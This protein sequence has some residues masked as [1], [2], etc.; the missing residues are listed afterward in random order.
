MMR[1]DPFVRRIRR[2][3]AAARDEPFAAWAELFREDRQ[4]FDRALEAAM[5]GQDPSKQ[6]AALKVL[7]RNGELR[8]KAA[9]WLWTLLLTE[10][11]PLE[12]LE[13]LEAHAHAHQ[14]NP[15]FWRDQALALA[16]T[17]LAWEAKRAADRGLGRDPGERMQELHRRILELRTL[18][19]RAHEFNEWEPFRRL[20]EVELGF[21]LHERAERTL[22]I[23]GRSLI[24]AKAQIGPLSEMAAEILSL[25]TPDRA[26]DFLSGIRTLFRPSDRR[27]IERF[28]AA[29]QVEPDEACAG[30]GREALCVMA[31]A[32]MALGRREDAILRLA[33]LAELPADAGAR[34]VLA[35]EV[36][37]DVLGRYGFELG[38]ARAGRKIFDVFPFYNELRMLD[39]RLHEMADW[40]DQFVIVES[41]QTF[42]GRPKPLVFALHR[43]RYA[44]FADKILHVVVDDYPP[45][46]DSAWAREFHQRNMGLN[47][48]S[49]RCAADDLVLITDVDEV[50][51]REA[52]A[53]FDGEFASLRMEQSRYFLNYRRI[54]AAGEQ[55]PGLTS[56][57]KARYLTTMGL[58][59][60]R[61]A[62]PHVP[63]RAK[64]FDAGWHFSSAADAGAIGEK[65]KDISH[66][67][68]AGH[69]VDHFG[70]L[71]EAIRS[72]GEPEP[73]WRRVDVDESFPAYVRRNRAELGDLIL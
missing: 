4:G 62:L 41:A 53:G 46:I 39:L 64:I 63:G 61:A 30:A 71:F 19:A 29:P 57:W 58:S 20:A 32:S 68:F 59:Y 16:C 37:R 45:Y 7:H 13:I 54:I 14:L 42:T 66:Q 50:V 36:T 6:M 69:G 3:I 49:G 48:L 51:A 44:Q 31:L 38:A 24:L 27:L 5:A 60:A 70:P 67:E 26:A 47:A 25:T 2:D 1:V 40:V 10:D 28:L 43:E 12:A 17:G 33:R 9:R 65:M 22:Q 52:L 34:L 18:E 73:G 72:G 21:G 15:A 56:V 23:A 11:R 35:R 55:Q 8:A